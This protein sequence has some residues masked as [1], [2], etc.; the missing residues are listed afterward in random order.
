MSATICTIWAVTGSLPAGAAA[1]VLRCRGRLA[2][3]GRLRR[4][5]GCRGWRCRLPPVAGEADDV[6]EGG[7]VAQF[8]VVVARDVEA[9]P[10][11]GEDFGL[12]DR[13][14]AEV[15]LQV[16]VEVEQFGRV[17]GHV[18]D[19]LDDLGRDE[20]QAGL[21]GRDRFQR[22]ASGAAA[23]GPAVAG[24]GMFARSRTNR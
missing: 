5:R 22:Q 8:E 1:A 20:V 19:D 12:L 14:D 6:G 16:E 23:G 7:E 2:R 4:A 9:C 18:G 21:T 24:A 10:D 11:G 15:G 17:A 13:V 3:G